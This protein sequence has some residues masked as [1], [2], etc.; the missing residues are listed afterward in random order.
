MA[1]NLQDKK[2]KPEG[3]YEVQ[4]ALHFRTAAMSHGVLYYHA[5]SVFLVPL[6]AVYLSGNITDFAYFSI[7]LTVVIAQHF[8]HLVAFIFAKPVFTHWPL[9]FAIEATMIG[10]LCIFSG[11]FYSGYK[12]L[13]FLLIHY[14]VIRLRRVITYVAGAMSIIT[15]LI[16]R[17]QTT[18][19]MQLL[20]QDLGVFSV[21]LCAVTVACAEISHFIQTSHEKTV[22]T[23]VQ[24]ARTSQQIAEQRHEIAHQGVK[25]RN[26]LE[27]VNAIPWEYDTKEDLFT[28][29]GPQV[30]H[31]LGH[32]LQEWVSKKQFLINIVN[33]EDRGAVQQLF[34]S[35]GGHIARVR[36]AEIRVL[37]I[38][39]NWKWMLCSVS[40]ST[41]TGSGHILQG[42]FFDITSRKRSDTELTKY[43]ERLEEMVEERTRALNEYATR[44]EKLTIEDPLTGL[45]NKR[46]FERE[47][48]K[49]WRRAQR[50]GEYIAVLIMDIDGFQFYNES[51][52]HLAGDTCL[53]LVARTLKGA[54]RRA[55]DFIA[56]FEG[57]E[58]IAVIPGA[59]E[60]AARVVA[61][62][63]RNAVQDLRIE[64][65]DGAAALLTISIGVAV[66]VP[67]KGAEQASLIAFAREALNGAK[68]Q[69]RNRS[70]LVVVSAAKSDTS[71]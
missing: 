57:E 54:L 26:L 18:G 30:T 69:G 38:E 40:A 16:L 66:A 10:L 42:V 64:Q 53:H 65:R 47:L 34:A 35:N 14:S 37:T 43:R 29:V 4:E 7:I 3:L 31:L 9:G 15:V 19:D 52:G 36:D 46:Y 55:G 41:K 21:F 13:Y 6:L 27:T 1:A 20:N 11:G 45:P 60:N 28:Y 22:A 71:A 56:R 2:Y 50:R 62:K 51:Y 70:V 23:V 8:V 68:V 61:E 58:F 48:D 32:P 39:G 5:L 63:M 12:Y 33:N 67:D 25:Y 59:D 44:L 24:Q 49:E 17:S